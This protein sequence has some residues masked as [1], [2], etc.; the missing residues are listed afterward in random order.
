MNALDG[1]SIAILLA[2]IG[3]LLVVAEVFFPSGGVLGFLSAAA[4]IGAVY[5][6]YTSGGLITGLT[7]AAV[8]VVLAP[9][10]IFF[11]FAYLPKTP[12][13]KVLIGA[14]PT[15]EEARPVDSHETI[16]GRVGVARTKML[17]AGSI[18]IDGRMLDAVSQGQA[19][20][21]GEY[22]KI[23]ESS[24]NRVVVRRAG[25]D[26]RPDAGSPTADNPLNRPA[27]ELGLE[28]FDFDRDAEA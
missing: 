27:E 8:E 17:P 4:F 25:P 28:S 6:A 11:T 21:P 5:S 19:I 22:V 7:F 23:I 12:M 18:E 9:L 1:L 10:L 2:V 14:A 15:G 3:S 13:G 24:G 26:E 16:V 20:D